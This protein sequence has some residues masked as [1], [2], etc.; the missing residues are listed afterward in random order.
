[1]EKKMTYIEKIEG[2]MRKT[3][4]WA[5]KEKKEKISEESVSVIPCKSWGRSDSSEW[6]SSPPVQVGSEWQASSG[7][8]PS[9]P[10]L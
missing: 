10:C 6:D 3:W 4:Q 1:M 7:E 2:K 5:S 9:G 8:E